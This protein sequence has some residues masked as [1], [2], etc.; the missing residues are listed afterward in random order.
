MD[1][2]NYTNLEGQNQTCS[3]RHMAHFTIVITLGF[4]ILHS[5]ITTEQPVPWSTPEPPSPATTLCLSG[6]SGF[7]NCSQQPYSNCSNCNSTTANGFFIWCQNGETLAYGICPTG[8]CDTQMTGCSCPKGICQNCTTTATCSAQG[9]CDPRGF[10]ICNPGY[11]GPAC[12]QPNLCTGQSDGSHCT[13]VYEQFI[14]Q[15]QYVVTNITC[16]LECVDGYGCLCP[17]NCTSPA[18]G[19]CQPTTTVGV[20]SCNSG[21]IDDDCSFDVSTSS[22]YIN[23]KA[24]SSSGGFTL[25]DLMFSNC[26]PGATCG[27]M[28]W[29]LQACSGPLTYV[30]IVTVSSASPDT[31][32]KAAMLFNFTM[33]CNPSCNSQVPASG[34]LEIVRAYSGIR[35]HPVWAVYLNGNETNNLY[36]CGTTNTSL[37]SLRCT[38]PPPPSRS[39]GIRLLPA[40]SI[41]DL[42]AIYYFFRAFRS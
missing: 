17:N 20:C 39:V 16:Q 31:P 26:V 28:Q 1:K 42:F 5:L 33:T 25:F 19:Q 10:C 15:N 4:T 35:K 14:C 18:N 40:L 24:I 7:Y 32:G 41:F 38:P 21:F 13:A 34:T 6:S 30:G 8:K 12:D 2:K 23:S 9:T 27:Q 3:R 37:F 22:Y 11:S 29:L 36:Q